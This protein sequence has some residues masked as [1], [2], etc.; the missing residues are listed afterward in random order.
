MVPFS[1]L[2]YS[3]P[4]IYLFICRTYVIVVV[5]FGVDIDI[6]SRLRNSDRYGG[7]RRP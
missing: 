5:K 2:S 6:Y 3:T 7:S 4:I 1:P